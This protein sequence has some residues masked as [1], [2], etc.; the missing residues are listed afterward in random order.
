[1][2]LQAFDKSGPYIRMLVEIVKAIRWFMLMMLI[3]ILATWNSFMLLL[4]RQA[5]CPEPDADASCEASRDAASVF[6]TMYDMINTLLFGNGDLNA[7]ENTEYFGLVVFI[8]I[9]SMIAMP[10][11]LLN[12]LIAIMG[13]SYELIQVSAALLPAQRATPLTRSQDRSLREPV[14][15]KARVLLVSDRRAAVEGLVLLAL[16]PFVL[17]EVMRLRP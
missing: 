13:D 12:M 16:Q 4:K 6:R 10:I 17:V 14:M 15:M 9:V 5:A 2:R 1:M 7:L 11:V 3:S 8:F